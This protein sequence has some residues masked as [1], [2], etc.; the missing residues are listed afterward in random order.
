[1]DLVPLYEAV[2][3]AVGQGA[4]AAV[5]KAIELT[6]RSLKVAPEIDISGNIVKLTYKLPDGYI[7]QSCISTGAPPVASED[8][9]EE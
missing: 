3:E 2:D 9:S 5:K 4:K 1:M 7:L 6:S 8:D